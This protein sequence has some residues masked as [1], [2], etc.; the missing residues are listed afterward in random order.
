MSLEIKLIVNGAIGIRTNCKAEGQTIIYP[1]SDGSQ[2][3][4]NMH[5]SHISLPKLIA[6]VI[7]LLAWANPTLAKN[8]L[9]VTN[10]NDVPYQEA[11]RGFEQSFSARDD[12]KFTE[13][14][15]P[16]SQAPD[17]KKIEAIKPDLIF[18]LGSEAMKWASQQTSRIPIVTTMVL[19][20]NAL[21]QLPNITGISLSYTLK[22]Q[23]Q[24]L[25]KFFP[26]QKSVAVLFNPAENNATVQEAIQTCHQIGIELVAIP[27][28]TP[29]E[30]PFALEQLSNKIEVLLSIPDD[31]AMSVNTAKEVLLASFRNKVPLVGLSD[32]WVKSGA[33]YA[34]SWDYVDL[35]QQS[36]VMAQK[37]LNGTPVSSISPEHPRKVTYTINAKIAEHMNM[38][39]PE[40]LLKNAKMVFN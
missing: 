15:I 26:Q 25:K 32:N 29:K 23:I 37:L 20:E 6:I 39:I 34:L 21:K 7:G 38:E 8:I 31:T 13:L 18:A 40:D 17:S 19:K 1:V 11:I 9:V 14:T 22:T 35:G 3:P 4:Y 10:S 5:L 33:Y 2:R 16:Q 12:V 24:W 27:V 30:L 28:A 36:A